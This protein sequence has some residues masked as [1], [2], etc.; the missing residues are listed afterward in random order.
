[1][2]ATTTAAV[3]LAGTLVAASCGADSDRIGTHRT[4]GADTDRSVPSVSMSD[5]IDRPIHD[6]GTSLPSTPS[7]STTQPLSVEA[8]TFSEAELAAMRSVAEIRERVTRS[9]GLGSRNLTEAPRGAYSA[10]ETSTGTGTSAGYSRRGVISAGERWLT[11]G[12][13][14]PRLAVTPAA[15][16]W[17]AVDY[18]CNGALDYAT[19]RRSAGLDA[20]LYIGPVRQDCP[21]N[22]LVEEM[23]EIAGEGTIAGVG[24]DRWEAIRYDHVGT[25]SWSYLGVRI[26]P[27]SK[28]RGVLYLI[29]GDERNYF[30]FI[31]ANSDEFDEFLPLAETLLG[32]LEID[33]H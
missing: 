5:V 21:F 7:S 16:G 6:L 15:E 12:Y 1:M 18:S 20:A 23:P 10:T 13:S 24:A 9:S 31:T 2:K 29:R 26:G 4:L 8:V 33:I 14:K 3:L 27:S 32:S 28:G 19:F 11:A 17:T 30:A 25:P 22:E